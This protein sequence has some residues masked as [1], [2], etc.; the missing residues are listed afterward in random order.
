MD[1]LSALKAAQDVDKFVGAIASVANKLKAQPDVAALKLTQ[2]LGEVAKTLQVVDR[3]TSDYLSLGVDDGALSKN[4]KLLLEIDGGSLATEVERG[5]GHCHKI[6][7]IYSNYLNKWFSR[8][9][10]PQE[11]A[12]VSKAFASLGDADGT[13]FY[14]LEM[15]AKALQRE[16]GDVLDLVVKN[17]EQSARARVKSAMAELRPFRKQPR[18]P[19]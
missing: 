16:A 7:H 12:A 18:K 1:L 4:A 6:E 11:S 9:L 10:D 5:R 15:V 17:E 19:C 13:L 2:A 3:A 14:Q 8:V